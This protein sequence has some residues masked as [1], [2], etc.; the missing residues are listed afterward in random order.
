MNFANS[1]IETINQKTEDEYQAAIVHQANSITQAATTLISFWVA[2][3]VAWVLPSRYSY[4]SL[5]MIVPILLGSIIGT[6]WL[7]NHIPVPVNLRLSKL[8]MLSV[9]ASGIL[10]VAGMWYS[11]SVAEP[12]S[13][14]WGIIGGAIVGFV[15]ALIAVPISMRNQRRRDIKRLDAQLGDD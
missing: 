4:I 12:A 6:R 7:R 9:G 14:H 3:I 8:E 15:F 13:S 10:W 2:A 11:V 1:V 5:L